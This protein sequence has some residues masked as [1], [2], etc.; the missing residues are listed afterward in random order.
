MNHTLK[1]TANPVITS[2]FSFYKIPWKCF[3]LSAQRASFLFLWKVLCCHRWT[4]QQSLTGGNLAY[5]SSFAIVTINDLCICN[6]IHRRGLYIHRINCQKLECW[7]QKI[8]PLIIFTDTA[9]MLF[10][11]VFSVYIL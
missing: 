9:K 10:V 1:T 8:H 6:F 11:E 5:F 2:L 3:Y 7:V 4:L